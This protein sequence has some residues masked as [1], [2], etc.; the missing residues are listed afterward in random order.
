M[1]GVNPE[2]GGAG[3]EVDRDLATDQRPPPPVLLMAENSE[4]VPLGVELQ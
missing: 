3:D 1:L 2:P 4:D